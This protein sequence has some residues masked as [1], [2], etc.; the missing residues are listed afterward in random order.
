METAKKHAVDIWMVKKQL[1]NT[2]DTVVRCLEAAQSQT[3]LENLETSLALCFLDESFNKP[4]RSS[5]TV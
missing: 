2:G 1:G 5:S 3:Y 4:V